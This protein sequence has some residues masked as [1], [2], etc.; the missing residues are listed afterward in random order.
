MKISHPLFQSA[1]L[2]LWGVS[3]ASP[4]AIAREPDF[5]CYWQDDSGAVVDLSGLCRGGGRSP[6]DA[7]TLFLQDF[8]AIARQ[9]PASVQPDLVSSITDFPD[10]AIAAAKTTCRVLR[11]A[12]PAAAQQRK[13]RLAALTGSASGSARQD[14]IHTL[15]LQHYCPD[16]AGR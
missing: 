11:F 14:L 13:A 3:V 2:L 5:L 16:L 1:L 10:S 15:A 8:Q 9:S 7:N 4:K 6:E 12:G